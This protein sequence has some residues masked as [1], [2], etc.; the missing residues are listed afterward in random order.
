MPSFSVNADCS[1]EVSMSRFELTGFEMGVMHLKLLSPSIL[2]TAVAVGAL[3]LACAAPTFAQGSVP[4]RDEKVEKGSFEPIEEEMR[5]KR[6][7]RLAQKEHQENLNRA[8]L[9]SCL[10]TEIGVAFKQKNHLDRDD[11]KKLDKL[12]KLAKSI[13]SAAGGSDDAPKIEKTSSDLPET[14]SKMTEV[15]ESLKEKVEKT[16]RRVI[17]AAVIDQANVLLELIRRVRG[18]S[19]RT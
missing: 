16:P 19:A 15:A 6:S 11:L 4:V 10:G 8:Q 14:V 17:S 5:I 7:I 2:R 1:F 9:L 18:L 12:E 3:F 13:R